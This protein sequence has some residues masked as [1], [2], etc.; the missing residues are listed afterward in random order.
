MKWKRLI[1]A[2]IGLEIVIWVFDLSSITSIPL[3]FVV[4]MMSQAFPDHI[5]TERLRVL[6]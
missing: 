1:L 3:G 6:Q 2:I 4:G 5:D